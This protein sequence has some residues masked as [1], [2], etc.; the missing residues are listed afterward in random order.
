L[1]GLASLAMENRKKEISI[2]KVLGASHENL[3]LLLS[4]DYILLV[5]VALICAIPLTWWFMQN[6]LSSFEYRVPVSAQA[7]LLSGGLSL[8]IALITISY[9]T[10][11]TAWQKPAETLK[12]E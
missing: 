6:W 3:L 1:Y 8:L 11:H 4:K 10:I 5:L 2:R 7:F 12:Y 9:Q